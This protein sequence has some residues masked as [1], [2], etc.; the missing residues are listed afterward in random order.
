MLKPFTKFVN[1]KAHNGLN[2]PAKVTVT[3]RTAHEAHHH[4]P[5]EPAQTYDASELNWS[6]GLTD[7]DCTTRNSNGAKSEPWFSAPCS[8]RLPALQHDEPGNA[9]TISFRGLTATTETAERLEALLCSSDKHPKAENSGCLNDI[10]QEMQTDNGS[11]H[12]W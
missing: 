8:A 1:Y 4:A 2:K 3:D 10:F 5:I 7:R 12:R 11:L 6:E 9:G